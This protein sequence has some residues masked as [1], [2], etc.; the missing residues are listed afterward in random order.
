MPLTRLLHRSLAS[1]ATALALIVAGPAALPASA[2]GGQYTQHRGAF[3]RAYSNRSYGP[4]LVVYTDRGFSGRSVVIA[5][6]AD[7]RG[8]RFNDRISSIEVLSGRWEACSDPGFRGRCEIIDY[9]E[10]QLARLG[11]NDKITSIR[12]VGRRHAG[13]GQRFRTPR[14][15]DEVYGG[16]GYGSNRGGGGG[17]V[18]STAAAPGNAP[19]VL[20]TDPDGRGR[21]VSIFGPE[22]HLN[23]LRINDVVSS[24]DV[25]RG[26][27]LVCSDPNYRG[28]C[29]VISGFAPR[30]RDF[31]LNDNISSIRPVDGG[32]SRRGKRWD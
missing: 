26:A 16:A 25:R 10:P 8:S 13:G 2:D 18:D 7:L 1:L 6:P 32:R 23:P 20:F 11:L 21:A 30:T 12:P 9:D 3:D 31:G 4:E 15:G 19:V 27:W 14:Y 28:R 29:E 17:F 22:P 5:R 24:I